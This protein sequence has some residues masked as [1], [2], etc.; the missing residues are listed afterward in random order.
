MYRVIKAFHDTE[1]NRVVQKGEILGFD[2]GRA[3]SLVDG[4]LIVPHKAK[5]AG[6]VAPQRA[7]HEAAPAHQAHP[8]AP[9]RP[10]RTAAPANQTHP[11]APTT[12]QHAPR[13]RGKGK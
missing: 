9:S 11:A 2:E 6:P 13:S 12:R 7:A 8:R 10:A 1:R 3:R 4:K 5:P